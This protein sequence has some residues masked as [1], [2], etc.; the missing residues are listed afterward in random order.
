MLTT[1]LHKK[2]KPL[3]GCLSFIS[4][5][6]FHILGPHST[7]NQYSF[8]S[9]HN[10]PSMNFFRCTKCGDAKMHFSFRDLHAFIYDGTV[11]EFIVGQVTTLPPLFSIHWT[12]AFW[13]PNVL[14]GLHAWIYFIGEIEIFARNLIC[15][16]CTCAMHGYP[17][18]SKQ[19]V[20]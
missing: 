19:N 6:T 7:I 3:V 17:N 18:K 14:E 2:F 8:N 20:V 13:K 11:L 12:I 15:F 10:S 4:R 1:N 9:R 16:R 5:Y